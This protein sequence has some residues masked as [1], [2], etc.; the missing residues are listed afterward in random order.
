M[1]LK[2][3][4]EYRKKYYQKITI[5]EYNDELRHVN[6]RLSDKEKETILSFFPDNVEHTLT[7]MN[8]KIEVSM[9]K[10]YN[11]SFIKLS[12][13]WYLISHFSIDYFMR[14]HN[15]NYYKCDQFEGLLK[16]L[17]EFKKEFK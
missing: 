1:R 10:L 6:E 15:H 9:P 13:E 2:L 12:D 14:D 4:E 7:L 11:V 17:V 3:F 16:W 8:D 5:T